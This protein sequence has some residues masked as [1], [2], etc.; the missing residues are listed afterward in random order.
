[1]YFRSKQMKKSKFSLLSVKASQD[2]MSLVEILIGLTLM[3]LA[4]TFIAGKVFNTLEEGRIEAA[5]I[6]IKGFEER[7]K[8]FR[9]HCHGYPTTEHGLAALV[10]KPAGL[11]CQR[12]SP[13]GYVENDKIPMDP[14]DA[15]YEYESN[16]KKFVI[17]S[18]GAD[19]EEGGE[20]YDS[21]IKS[22]D[23]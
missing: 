7:L 11:E 1:M 5:K 9:R 14:W 10:K 8:E 17:T 23:L 2:G 16:G 4:G 18:L 21:D 6:Q 20:G 19:K 13:Q 15:E 3:G 22:T 12:Y